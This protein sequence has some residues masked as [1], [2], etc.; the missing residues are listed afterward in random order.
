[1]HGSFKALRPR[2]NLLHADQ[3]EEVY[4]GKEQVRQKTLQKVEKAEDWGGSLHWLC[5][6][7]DMGYSCSSTIWEIVRNAESQTSLQTY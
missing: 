1:M 2:G 3:L 5:G 4:L 6:V 7:G